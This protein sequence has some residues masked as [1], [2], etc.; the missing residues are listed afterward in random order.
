MY[1]FL[2]EKKKSWLFVS[3]L[4]CGGIQYV[5]IRRPL[6]VFFYDFS[7]T[8]TDLHDLCKISFFTEC[9]GSEPSAA[10]QN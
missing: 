10:Q 8:L 1:S 3:S 6:R 4:S 9:D 5:Q 2:L 7:M